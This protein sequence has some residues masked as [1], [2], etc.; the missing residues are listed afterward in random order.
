M[1]ESE[2]NFEIQNSE[3]SWILTPEEQAD[4]KRLQSKYTTE[5]DREEAQLYMFTIIN[6]LKIIFPAITIE[7][8]KA[9]FSD[10]NRKIIEDIINKTMNKEM[11]LNYSNKCN[12]VR[13]L[14]A[15]LNFSTEGGSRRRIRRR[16]NKKKKTKKKRGSQKKK[17]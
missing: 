11:L 15:A 14:L 5:E 7:N 17:K 9:S 3:S 8:D 13:L 1:T 4:I 10:R 12:N 6:G 2:N 16:T